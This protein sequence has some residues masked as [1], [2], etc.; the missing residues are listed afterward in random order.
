MKHKPI[1]RSI[2]MGNDGGR[3]TVTVDAAADALGVSRVSLYN[4]INRGEFKPVIRI[5]R[6]ILIPKAALE[7]LL[8]SAGSTA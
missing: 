1:E 6:R 8:A 4:A 7:K 3:L 2:N 5:G